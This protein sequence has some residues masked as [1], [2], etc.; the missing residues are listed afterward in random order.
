M[1]G[2][3]E[4]MPEPLWRLEQALEAR[5]AAGD[6][7]VPPYPAVAL[8]VQEAMGRKNFGL[9]EVAGLIGADAVLAADILR[10]ANSV[11]YRRGTPVID[12]TQ[13]LTRIG[14]QQV[15]RL[16]LASGLAVHA[17]AVGPLV[18]LRRM[19]WIEGLAG[20]AICQEL[21]RLRG[22]RCEDAF[23]LGLLH[24]FGKIVAISVLETMLEAER[25]Q[26]SFSRAEWEALI[27]RQHVTLGLVMGTRWRLPAL[28]SEVIAGH[29]GLAAPCSDPRLLQVVKAS[30]QV[31]ALLLSRPRVTG[32]ELASVALLAPAE[33][34]AVARV[35]EQVPDFVAAFE[36]PAASA[37]VASARIAQPVTTLGPGR[38]PV[39]FGVSI[40]VARRPRLFTATGIGEDGLVMSGEEP[41]PENRLLEAK[42]F[43]PDPFTVWVLSRL[44]RREGEA[45]AVEVQPFALSGPLRELWA[46]LVSGEPPPA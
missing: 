1:S 8:K 14:V 20:A 2:L 36:T 19:V 26:E 34:E 11:M 44:S 13:A 39:K 10:C 15:M 7:Q 18:P 45:F 29:H 6:V 46:Q 24:D 33:R 3:P 12:L 4:T 5:A 25:V 32:A 17:Q 40:S 22:L 21:A 31:V 37:A 41:L 28:V 42:V 27:E 35:L 38:R 16:L 9:G 23:T 43:G 30:D